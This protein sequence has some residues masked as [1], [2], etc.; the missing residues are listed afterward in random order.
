MQ[1]LLQLIIQ[2]TRNL[3]SISACIHSLS[4]VKKL[5]SINKFTRNK[6]AQ[7]GSSV[8]ILFYSLNEKV[9]A[10][11]QYQASQLLDR[12]LPSWRWQDMIDEETSL[13]DANLLP[14]QSNHLYS[15]QDV[16]QR[17]ISFSPMIEPSKKNCGCFCVAVHLLLLVE[18]M[19]PPRNRDTYSNELRQQSLN[20]Q[21]GSVLSVF[22]CTE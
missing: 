13:P 12:R 2:A 17:L 15:Q 21:K 3:L 20:R 14:S 8:S 9:Y 11:M 22:Y 4:V 7:T 19:P 6:K 10:A 5:L 18:L 16:H 1:F